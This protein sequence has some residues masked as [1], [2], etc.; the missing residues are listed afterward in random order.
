MGRRNISAGGDAFLRSKNNLKSIADMQLL[1][2][3][4]H[5][6]L[7]RLGTDGKAKRYFLVRLPLQQQLNN[8]LFPNAQPD[9][10]I[11][12]FLQRRIAQGENDLRRN[13]LGDKGSAVNAT[14]LV[15]GMLREIDA[16]ASNVFPGMLRS[17]M[18]TSGL[19]RVEMSSASAAVP[20]FATTSKALSAANMLTIP[21]SK[22]G[23]SSTN[24]IEYLII[25]PGP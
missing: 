13:A 18:I 12:T 1:H 9:R 19:N 2:Q 11:I 3:D 17:T 25:F 24:A 8:L 21:S 6:V 23:W 10:F 7:D 16:I 22:T 4:C 5:V 20:P 14:I 15:S